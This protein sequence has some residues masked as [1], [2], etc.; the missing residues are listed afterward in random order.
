MIT[1]KTDLLEEYQPR[2]FVNIGGSQ[3]NLGNAE[4]VLR[5][6]PGLVPANQADR[7][8]NGMIGVAM[9]KI[10]PVIHMLNVKS[11][12]NRVGIPYDSPPRKLAPARVSAWWS[13]FGVIL[14]FSILLT[15]TRWR[16]EPPE[17]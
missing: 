9:R 11:I 12:S 3:T 8:G 5:L 13:V 10:I 7:A 16:L 6:S 4:E 14:F 17:T 2:L 15:H 1:R